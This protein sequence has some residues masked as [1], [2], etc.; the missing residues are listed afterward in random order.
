MWSRTPITLYKIVRPNWMDDSET[1]SFEVLHYR[2]A[3]TYLPGAKVTTIHPAFFFLSRARAINYLADWF[4]TSSE[5]LADVELWRCHAE[6]IY[7]PPSHVPPA[8]AVDMF[9][10]FWRTYYAG[11]MEDTR[12]VFEGLERVPRRT[13]IAFTFA[14]DVALP[15]PSDF[16]AL[17]ERSINQ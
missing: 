6:A 5:A 1:T 2:H 12:H 14:L 10:I 11:N 17:K 9:D 13:V 7:Q 4:A 15:L 8:N 3:L 16:R